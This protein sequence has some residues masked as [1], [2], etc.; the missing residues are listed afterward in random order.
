MQDLICFT[1]HKGRNS[2]GKGNFTLYFTIF[3]HGEL[4]FVQVARTPACQDIESTVSLTGKGP[5]LAFVPGCVVRGASTSL[6]H[7]LSTAEAYQ[8]K[9]FSGNRI[10]SLS[11]P[12]A[13]LP[14]GTQHRKT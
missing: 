11:P 9:R 7:I 8:T 6:Q 13:P 10:K 5:E 1:R 3:N 12:F 4:E 2:E 14:S